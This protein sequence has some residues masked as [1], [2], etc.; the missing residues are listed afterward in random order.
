M[1]TEITMK[2]THELFVTLLNANVILPDFT[3]DDMI[4]CTIALK[5]QV[6]LKVTDKRRC[7][8]CNSFFF[9]SWESYYCD[10]CGQRLDWSDK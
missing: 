3:F 8:S 2:S 4:N 10:V 9:E 1:N 5:K 7:P 6:P